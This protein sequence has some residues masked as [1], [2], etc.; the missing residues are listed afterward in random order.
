MD[1]PVAIGADHHEVLDPRLLTGFQRRKRSDMVRLDE[2]ITQL[3]VRFTKAEAADFAVE[4]PM[5]R[6]EPALSSLNQ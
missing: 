1:H 2:V 6:L 3:T 4:A 5:F